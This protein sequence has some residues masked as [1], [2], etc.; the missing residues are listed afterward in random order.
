MP[1]VHESYDEDIPGNSTGCIC[2]RGQDHHKELIGIRVG[3]ELEGED[4]GA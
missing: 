3:E 2:C 4:N 1:K